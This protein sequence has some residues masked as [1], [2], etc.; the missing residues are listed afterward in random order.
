MRKLLLILLGIVVILLV[1]AVGAAAW[2]VK[3]FDDPESRAS[4]AFKSRFASECVAAGRL[5]TD[6]Q[7]P[8]AADGDRD[9]LA[10]VCNCGA[11]EMRDDIAET[12]L[13]GLARMF[14]IE[15]MDEKMQRVL[16]NCQSTPSAP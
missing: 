12:G 15:G 9:D 8:D 7:D 3:Q 11:D 16:N 4:L 2:M 14:L 6:G 13:T 10:A 5:P 1:L